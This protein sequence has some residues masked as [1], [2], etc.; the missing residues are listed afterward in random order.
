MSLS[1]YSCFNC[2]KQLSIQDLELVFY[3]VLT[4]TIVYVSSV[5]SILSTVR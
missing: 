1:Y 3:T 2:V 5:F 4:A